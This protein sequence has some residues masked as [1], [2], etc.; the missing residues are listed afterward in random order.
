MGH[1]ENLQMHKKGVRLIKRKK[2]KLKLRLKLERT[3]LFDGIKKFAFVGIWR[4]PEIS[5][6]LITYNLVLIIALIHPCTPYC[7]DYFVIII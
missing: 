2:K 7:I 5:S 1:H 4:V 3:M 6:L